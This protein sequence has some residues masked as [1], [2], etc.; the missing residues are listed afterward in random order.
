MKTL[1]LIRHGHAV[2]PKEGLPDIERPL[3]KK[4]KAYAS[5]MAKQLKKTGLKVDLI[6]SSPAERAVTMAKL[7]AKILKYSMDGIRQEK[8]VYSHK[9]ARSFMN[10]LHS[11]EDKNRTVMIFGHSPTLDMFASIL[12]KGFQLSMP[13]AGILGIELDKESWKEINRGCGRRIFY[14]YPV[15]KTKMTKK[16]QKELEKKVAQTVITLF[17]EVDSSASKKI[18]RQV[19]A[20]SSKLVNLFINKS[21]DFK[22]YYIELQ[23]QKENATDTEK[24]K[25]ESQ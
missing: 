21:K 17:N 24:N 16:V 22:S 7:Y 5:S 9:T 12:I 10:I 20:T 14:D 15:N 8:L 19:Q 3:R 18:Q 23:A 1:Y 4:G 13:K 25:K 6:I 2:A 11:I